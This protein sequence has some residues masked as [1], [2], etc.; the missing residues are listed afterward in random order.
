MTDLTAGILLVLLI[1]AIAAVSGV[2]LGIFL[3]APRI[4]RVLDGAD[5]EDEELGDRPD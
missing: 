4:T 5:Q 2:A 3:L 1:G